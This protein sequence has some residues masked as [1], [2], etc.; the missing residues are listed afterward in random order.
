MLK[1][2]K[3]LKHSHQISDELG[4]QPKEGFDSGFCKTVKWY[5]ENKDW[6]EQILS[7][8]Y[9]LDRFGKSSL[10]KHALARPFSIIT[11]QRFLVFQKMRILSPSPPRVKCRNINREPM[12]FDF[13]GKETTDDKRPKSRNLDCPT[14]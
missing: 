4:W 12:N 8:N 14:Y 9:K 13:I 2:A 6:W 5:L 1:L 7:G 3:Q 11:H 10:Y